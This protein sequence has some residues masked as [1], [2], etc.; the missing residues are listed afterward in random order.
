[1]RGVG[2]HGSLHAYRRILRGA[3]VSCF[4]LLVP[5]GVL[6]LSIKDLLVLNQS[7]QPINGPSADSCQSTH[8]VTQTRHA[9]HHIVVRAMTCQHPVTNCSAP[10]VWTCAAAACFAVDPALARLTVDH[11]DTPLVGHSRVIRDGSPTGHAGHVVI[12]PLDQRTIGA[13]P[14]TND[15]A[16][17]LASKSEQRWETGR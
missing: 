14:T 9:P 6:L 15:N 13:I 12:N 2:A 3:P 17:L 16:A 11:R 5:S 1:M 10:K 8:S 4:A 7:T